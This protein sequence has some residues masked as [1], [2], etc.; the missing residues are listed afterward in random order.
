MGPRQP[1]ISLF[2]TLS[3]LPKPYASTP[4]MVQI[5]SPSKWAMWEPLSLPQGHCVTTARVYHPPSSSLP[6]GSARTLSELKQDPRA[7]TPD[8]GVGGTEAFPAH[9][10][11]PSDSSGCSSSHSRWLPSVSCSGVA[12]SLSLSKEVIKQLSFSHCLLVLLL[13]DRSLS[14]SGL[15]CVR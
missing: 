1:L 5:V 13:S 9:P 12:T 4:T 14:G 15:L 10:A 6:L 2:P 11:S 8:D 7:G 3:P